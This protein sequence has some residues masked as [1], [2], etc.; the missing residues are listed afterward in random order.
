VSK[1][2]AALLLSCSKYDLY[3]KCTLLQYITVEI[4]AQL[5]ACILQPVSSYHDRQDKHC[6]IGNRTAHIPLIP[7]KSLNFLHT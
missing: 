2:F 7:S 5:A 4:S 1:T 6:T 3:D